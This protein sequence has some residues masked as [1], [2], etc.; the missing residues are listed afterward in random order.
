MFYQINMNNLLTIRILQKNHSKNHHDK[1]ILQ[2]QMNFVLFTT[3]ILRINILGIYYATKVLQIDK[4]VFTHL[5]LQKNF[6]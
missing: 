6:A 1:D 5:I 3:S 4:F 2:S